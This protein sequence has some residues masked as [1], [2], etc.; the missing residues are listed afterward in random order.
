VVL[1]YGDYGPDD[2]WR[3]SAGRAPT[4]FWTTRSKKEWSGL[5]RHSP[6]EKKTY[7]FRVVIQVVINC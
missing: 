1:E 5:E 4:P 6:W 2:S 7:I 3:L